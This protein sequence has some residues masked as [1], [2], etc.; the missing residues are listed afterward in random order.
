VPS[1][2]TLRMRL[3]I[4]Y[5][6]LRFCLYLHTKPLATY[7]Q[8]TLTALKCARLYHSFS[9]I[10]EAFCNLNRDSN[11]L[12]VEWSIKKSFLTMYLRLNVRFSIDTEFR[13]GSALA[14]EMH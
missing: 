4:T 3:R 2:H 12:Y 6:Y 11:Y 13:A 5:L 10:Y 8:L 1:S 9:L 14:L 7:L